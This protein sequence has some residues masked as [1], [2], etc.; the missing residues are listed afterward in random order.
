MSQEMMPSAPHKDFEN[1][2]HVDRSGVE[3]WYAR[4]LL[5]LLGYEKWG[6]AEEVIGRAARACINSGQD[7]DNHF[8]RTG[9]MVKIGST[10]MREVVDYKLDRYA[11]YLIAQNGDSNKPAVAHAQTYFALQTRRQEIFEQLP[12]N[13]KRLF[14]RGEISSH[15]KKLFQTAKRAG[16]SKFGLFNDAGYKGLYGMPLSDIERTKGIKKGE[17]LDRAGSTEL[18]ANLFRITQTDEKLQKD[19]VHGERAASRTHFM[20]GGKIRKTI[21]EI[22]GV[23]PEKLPTETHIQKVK[24]K[25][26]QSPLLTDE[27]PRGREW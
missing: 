19:N 26:K 18:A 5:P 2:K 11:C 27:K 21:K 9:K 16:V 4:V 25:M 15:N 3:Y 24:K 8:H 14:I 22:G 10:A 13:E 23:L 1:N 20:V 6:K 7:V 17:L 12:A